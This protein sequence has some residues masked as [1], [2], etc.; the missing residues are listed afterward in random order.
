[1]LVGH[2]IAWPRDVRWAQHQEP[3]GEDVEDIAMHSDFGNVGRTLFLVS[4][5]SSPL[6]CLFAVQ[7][8]LVNVASS[9][10][11]SIH[12]LMLRAPDSIASYLYLEGLAAPGDLKCQ[13][14]RQAALHPTSRLTIL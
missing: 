3:K 1:M 14:N 7:P 13:R 2:V 12:D 9:P 10:M 8:V 11:T 4:R 6:H 5:H